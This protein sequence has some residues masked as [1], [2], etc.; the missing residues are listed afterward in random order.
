MSPRTRT[1]AAV[2]APRPRSPWTC[3]GDPFRSGRVREEEQ[4]CEARRRQVAEILPCQV[5]MGADEGVPVAGELE[6][7]PVGLPLPPA[8]EPGEGR[9]AGEAVAKEEEH[10]AREV[11]RLRRA[12]RRPQEGDEADG[13]GHAEDGPLQDVAGAPMPEL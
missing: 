3:I 12:E 11:V 9:R 10:R 8:G 2:S 13:A 6:R 7:G 4:V 1:S 5:E